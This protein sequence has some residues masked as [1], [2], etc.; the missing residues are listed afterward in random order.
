MDWSETSKTK[1]HQRFAVFSKEAL[2]EI[3]FAGWPIITSASYSTKGQS[4]YPSA[5]EFESINGY[6]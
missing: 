4:R 2:S 5:L 1:K 6:M 3:A